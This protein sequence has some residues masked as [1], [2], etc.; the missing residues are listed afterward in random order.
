MTGVALVAFRLHEFRE[1]LGVGQLQNLC[2]LRVG[3]HAR[4]GDRNAAV[5]SLVGEV[6]QG[7]RGDVAETHRRTGT[8]QPVEIGQ[9]VKCCKC[10]TASF[11]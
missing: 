8:Q 6:G 1:L 3:V 10:S 9:I 5:G 4:G 11:G 2:V 7:V